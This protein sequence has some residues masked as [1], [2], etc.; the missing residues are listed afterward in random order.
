MHVFWTYL[1]EVTGVFRKT[2]WVYVGYG[3][4][5]V[6]GSV[7][8]EGLDDAAG[9]EPDEASGEFLIGAGL[10]VGEVD[11]LAHGGVPRVELE[12]RVVE[13]EEGVENLGTGELGRVGEDGGLGLGVVPV[14][15]GDY[16]IYDFGELGVEGRFSVSGKSDGVDRSSLCLE[17][18][19]ACFEHLAYLGR[20]DIFQR[21]V[22]GFPVPAAFAIDA[23]VGTDFVFEGQ[24]IDSEGTAETAAPYRPYDGV[25][26]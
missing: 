4:S 26:K 2:F 13:F 16:D 11:T 24:E 18:L 21:A 6:I 17:F 15:K 25:F 9:T 7:E 12:G 5:L 14:A 1:L 8:E 3:V 22:F 20:G 23:V 10:F 19:E